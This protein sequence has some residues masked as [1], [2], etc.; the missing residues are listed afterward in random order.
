MPTPK[1]SSGWKLAA[2]LMLPALQA[3]STTCA[4]PPPSTPKLP[5]TPLPAE[6]SQINTSDSQPLLYKARAW[7]ESLATW[8][9]REMPK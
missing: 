4:P 2:L 9:Q 6:I 7:L 3:C 5:V 1:K 8:S